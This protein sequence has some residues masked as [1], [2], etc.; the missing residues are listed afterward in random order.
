[1][2]WLDRYLRVH[3][4]SIRPRVM[5]RKLNA[6]Q[7]SWTWSSGWRSDQGHTLPKVP[8]EQNEWEQQFSGHSNRAPDSKTHV[9]HPYGRDCASDARHIPSYGVGKSCPTYMCPWQGILQ[10]NHIY[11]HGSGFANHQDYGSERHTNLTKHMQTYNREFTYHTRH[12]QSTPD[13]HKNIK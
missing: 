4:G 2:W 6:P 1:M 8:P 7:E 9:G 12:R 10:V 5:W 3:S 13:T 11:C